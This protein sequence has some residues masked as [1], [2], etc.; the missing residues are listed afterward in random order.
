MAMLS[1]FL[2]KLYAIDRL[3][4]RVF[5]LNIIKKRE[6][7]HMLSKTL[8]RIFLDYHDI[9]VGL[10]SY[11]NCFD[12]QCFGTHAKIGR[13]CS[14]APGVCRFNGNHPLSFKSMHPFFYNTSYRYVQDEKISR[15]EIVIGNDVWIGQNALILPSV[16]R[17]GDGAVV[18]AGAVVTKDVPDFAVVVGNPAKIAKYRFTSEIIEKIKRE[19]WWD[20]DIEELKDNIEEFMRPVEEVLNEVQKN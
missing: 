15:S 7:G 10:Y 4:L 6:G 3:K 14:I 2:Y 16:S 19:A 12:S 13:Y 1:K 17:I 5:L 8:R 20:K 11:G 9:E 18:G